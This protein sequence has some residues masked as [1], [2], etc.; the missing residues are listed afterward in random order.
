MIENIFNFLFNYGWYNYFNL[1][2]RDFIYFLW[3]QNILISSINFWFLEWFLYFLNY[4]L[5]YSFF[6][7]WILPWFWIDMD[8]D[9]FIVLKNFLWFIW[10][11]FGVFFWGFIFFLFWLFIK[12]LFK[13]YEKNLKFIH[14]NFFNSFFLFLFY[15][16]L[17]FLIILIL[18]KIFIIWDSKITEDENRILYSQIIFVAWLSI[19][20]YFLKNFS[21][22]AFKFPKNLAVFWVFFKIIPFFGFLWNFFIAFSNKSLKTKIFL[23]FLSSLFLVIFNAVCLWYLIDLSYIWIERYNFLSNFFST[24]DTKFMFFVSFLLISV[25]YEFLVRKKSIDK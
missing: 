1:V 2:I 8:F 20:L 15:S 4:F 18:Y 12:Y 25:T 16:S 23:I 21:Y 6:S 7:F 22:K 24:K 10:I 14:N 17:I 5:Y 13:K 3:I 9:N 11:L 19:I